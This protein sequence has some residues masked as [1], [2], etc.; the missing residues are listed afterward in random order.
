MTTKKKIALVTGASRGLGRNTALRLAEDGIDLIVTY[1]TNAADAAGVVDAAKAMGREA[2]AMRLDTGAVEEFGGFAD[3][4]RA[5]LRE[6]WARDSFDILVNNAGNGIFAPFAGVALDDFD[7]MMNVHFRGVFFLT[8][9]LLPL[10]A[11]DGAGR[12]VNLSSGLTRFV[13][14]GS[15]AYASVKGAVEV[16]TRYLARE[17]GPRGI[18]VNIVA[19]GP[20]GTDF[21]GGAMRDDEQVREA[22][23][24]QTAFGRVGRPD[25]I[26]GVIAA[27]AGDG[28][29]WVTAQRIEA[30][31]GMLL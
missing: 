5:V 30:S 25:D 26:G 17:L 16:L 10:L 29:G 13:G 27:L 23:G 7:A 3:D 28:M 21:N 18:T 1:R 19:P 12:I 11:D 22:L 4:V 9:R 14:D 31:G 8:Q 6:R 24:G 2:V 15:A 20:V